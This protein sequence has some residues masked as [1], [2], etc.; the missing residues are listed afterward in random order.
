M[1]KSSIVSYGETGRDK[2][3]GNASYRG[4]TDGGIV[5]DFLDFVEVKFGRPAQTCSDY[6]SGSFTTRDVC[7]EKGVDGVWTDLSQGFNMLL[8]DI[9][10]RPENIF[11]HPPYSSVIGIP[12]AGREWDDKLFIAKYGYD[13]KKY[14]LG[15]MDWDEF[16]KAMNYSMMKQYT[17][18]ETGGYIGVLMGDIRRK[19]V[20]HSMLLELAKPGDIVSI[21]IKKQNN[22]W[23]GNKNYANRNFIPIEQEYFLILHKPNPY[24]LDFSYVKKACLDIRDSLKATWK[25]LVMSILESQ[26]NHVWS[27]EEIYSQIEGHKKTEKNPNWK[28]KVRQTLQFLRKNGLI[29]FSERGRYS[30][31]A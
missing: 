18:L 9:P 6:M 19:G 23:S 30:L 5:K 15:R 20:Y 28:A 2:R 29:S 8:D 26:K 3:Y 7:L 25:D 21:V 31:A 16:V 24:T 17:A 22:T 11:W 4:N 14:D 1:F 27:L 12:Y 10:D 13:P